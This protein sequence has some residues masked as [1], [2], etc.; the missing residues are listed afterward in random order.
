MDI[1][2]FRKL[3]IMGIVRGARADIIDRLTD[4]VIEAG[5]KTI[6][7]TMNTPAAV[8]Q[9]RRMNK[10]AQGELMIGAGTVLSFNEAQKAIDAGASFIV[11][12][13]LVPD[14]VK[15]CKRKKIPVF[16]GAFTPQEVY[17]AWQAGATM[18]KVFPATFFG[19]SFFKELK[20]P[21]NNI[22]LLACGGVNP[23]NIRSFFSSG[24]S[25]VSFG[26]SIFKKERLNKKK[27][28]FIKKDIQNLISAYK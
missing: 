8:E 13:V 10:A 21:F 23:D 7:I 11:S 14:V 2:K 12:P 4:V 25:A 27:F 15:F 18:V 19:P 16:P 22:E 6:E 5:L 17:D 28:S 26:E 20:G 24:A 9:I 3:P 1:K